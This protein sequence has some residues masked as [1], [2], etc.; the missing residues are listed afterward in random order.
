MMTMRHDLDYPAPTRRN[1]E[2]FPS[3]GDLF[4]SFFSPAFLG[5]QSG[6]AL[7]ALD[8]KEMPDHYVVEVDVPGFTMDQ[9]G[10]QFADDVLTLTGERPAQV[11]ETSSKKG[12]EPR[13]HV[14]ERK[15][16]SFTRSIKFPVPVDSAHVKASL[17]SG[18][19]TVTV[20]KGMEAR[21]QKI[22][23]TEG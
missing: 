2:T 10:V 4:Q 13:W 8:L 6:P 20:P 21:T 7:P 17:K 11:T 9:I 1:L 12:E 22:K 14:V 5:S 16:G 23:V 18:V 19:L 15:S 3:I